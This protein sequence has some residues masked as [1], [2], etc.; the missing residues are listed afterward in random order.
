MKNRLLVCKLLKRMNFKLNLILFFILNQAAVFGQAFIKDIDFDGINDTVYIDIEKSTIICKLSTE[1]FKPISSKPIEILNL[2][3]GIMDAKNG[4]IFYND[5]MRAGYKNQFR[6]NT[7]TKKV[8]LIGMSQYAYGNA[9]ND[10]SGESSVNLLTNDY[11]GNWNFFDLESDKLI[12]IP[13]IKT[14]MKFGIINLEDFSEDTYFDYDEKSSEL[15]YKNK[16][17]MINQ[18]INRK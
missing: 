13:T 9:A 1:N 5:W 12:K 10:G 16:E 11:I 3:S 15:Y 4:F 7:K 17:R 14:K 2:S 6:Y 18:I 8:Q